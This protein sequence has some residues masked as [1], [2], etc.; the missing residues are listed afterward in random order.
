MSQYYEFAYVTVCA[1]VASRNT[2]GFLAPRKNNPYLYGPFELPYRSRDE[3]LGSIKLVQYRQYSKEMEPATSRAWIMQESLLACRVLSYSYQSVAW[4][5]RKVNHSDGGPTRDWYNFEDRRLWA[6]LHDETRMKN[7]QHPIRE[8]CHLIESYTLRNLT[9]PKDRLPAI[10]GIAHKYVQILEKYLRIHSEWHD[11]TKQ[12]PRPGLTDFE[13]VWYVAGLWYCKAERQSPPE[14]FFQQLLWSTSYY[15]QCLELFPGRRWE[16]EVLLPSDPPELRRRNY[17]IVALRGES[18]RRQTSSRSVGYLAPSWSWAAIEAPINY[19]CKDTHLPQA[20]KFEVLACETS[21]E[22]SEASFGNVTFGHLIVNGLLIPL[23]YGL[24]DSFTKKKIGGDP[25]E[26]APLWFAWKI[27]HKPDTT[28][29]A[30]LLSQISSGSQQG[31]ILQ[32]TGEADWSASKPIDPNWTANSPKGLVLV[33]DGAH[34]RRIGLCSIQHRH[35]STGGV[36]EALLEAY[37]SR[38]TITII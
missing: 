22:L 25:G 12:L 36:T 31:W 26:Q 5:C 32:V 35:S 37:G 2:E 9:D 34:Y 10:S 16:S 6:Q 20:S 7:A 19:E 24:Y 4:S 23:Q 33:A 28:E 17:R 18:S 38:E 27:V 11:L 3:P 13:G 1:S 30:I 14:M 21:L 8:L 15:K 29:S